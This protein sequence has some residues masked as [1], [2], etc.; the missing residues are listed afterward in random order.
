[1]KRTYSIYKEVNGDAVER[2]QCGA[3]YVERA[4]LAV[5]NIIYGMSWNGVERTWPGIAGTAVLLLCGLIGVHFFN[6]ETRPSKLWVPA[7]ARALRDNELASSWFAPPRVQQILFYGTN[8]LQN[9]PQIYNIDSAVENLTV[10]GQS[11]EYVLADICFKAGVDCLELSILESWNWTSTDVHSLNVSDVLKKVNRANPFLLKEILGG[12]ERNNQGLIESAEVA[13]LTYFVKTKDIE[14]PEKRVLKWEEAFLDLCTR[15]LGENVFCMSARSVSDMTF[16]GV[17]QDLPFVTF[18]MILSVLVLVVNLAAG[19][20][21]TQRI[22]VAL[23]CIACSIMSVIFAVGLASAFEFSY[24]PLHIIIAYIVHGVTVVK[25]LTFITTFDHIS[26]C[27][28]YDRNIAATYLSISNVVTGVPIL[29]C[30]VTSSLI[31]LAAFLLFDIPALESFAVFGAFGMLAST[32]FVLLF[33]S[34]VIVLNYVRMGDRRDA[35][36]WCI[37]TDNNISAN[38]QPPR[39]PAKVVHAAI[40]SV[41]NLNKRRND[42]PYLLFKIVAVVATLAFLAVGVIGVTKQRQEFDPTWMIPE[43]SYLTDYMEVS[44]KYFPKRG[45]P[46]NLYFGELDYFSNLTKLLQLSQDLKNLWCV[47]GASVQ[48][49]LPG[50]YQ[51]ANSSGNITQEVNKRSFGYKLIEFF[52]QTPLGQQYLKDVKQT[53]APDGSL[54]VKASRLSF[55]FVMMQNSTYRVKA[56]RDARKLLD[57]YDLGQDKSVVYGYDMLLWESD[58]VILQNT[59]LVLLIGVAIVFVVHL[60]FTLNLKSTVLAT[61][62]VAMTMTEVTGFM[63]FWGVPINSIS[64]NNLVAAMVLSVEIVTPSSMSLGN[65]LRSEPMVVVDYLTSLRLGIVRA[66]LINYLAYIPLSFASFYLFKTTFKM[67]LMAIIFSVFHSVVFIPVVWSFLPISKLIIEE[68][69]DNQVENETDKS[70]VVSG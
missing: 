51:W 7:D 24:G 1:M 67:M 4:F 68:Q 5:S 8:V 57:S 70:E 26:W 2:L 56:M 53:I 42:C 39:G 6:V 43:E 11:K 13:A 69:K 47:N 54:I 27:Y 60:V 61:V 31:F 34:S 40:E 65:L 44:E 55:E 58:A 23:S 64:A 22:Y 32:L 63:H 10:S 12:I 52:Y 29:T 9:I 14:N 66:G 37:K 50:F 3:P 48:F 25:C 33:F 19:T 45:Y 46:A 35:C 28:K 18:G 16:E 38:M 15:S 49:W 21:F 17:V 20:R 36:C 62:A 59:L 30:G 41:R